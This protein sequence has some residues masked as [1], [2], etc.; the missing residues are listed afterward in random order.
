M[1]TYAIP[2]DAAAFVV[3][4]D[5]EGGHAVAED[6]R[7][8]RVLIACRDEAQAREVADRLNRGGHG[9]SVRVDVLP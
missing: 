4:R 6:R 2:A 5:K 1:P 3:V 9:G 7:P 8:P